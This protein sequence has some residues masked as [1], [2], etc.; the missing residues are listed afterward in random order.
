VITP[1]AALT[2]VS[3]ECGIAGDRGIISI[4]IGPAVG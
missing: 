4:P 1:V 3:W 2:T